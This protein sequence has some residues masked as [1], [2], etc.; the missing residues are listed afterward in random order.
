MLAEHVGNNILEE[1]PIIDRPCMTQDGLSV[2]NCG[3]REDEP[4]KEG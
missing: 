3:Y 4:S 1:I 2:I